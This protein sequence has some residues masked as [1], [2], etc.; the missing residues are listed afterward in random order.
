MSSRS[1]ISLIFAFFLLV[2]SAPRALAQTS[3]AITDACN[4]PNATADDKAQLNCDT[5]APAID[6]L[7]SIPCTGAPHCYG[8]YDKAHLQPLNPN[9]LT[10]AAKFAKAMN[11]QKPGSV[12]VC[13]AARTSQ[14]QRDSCNRPNQAVCGRKTNCQGSLNYCPHV[15]GIAIDFN[16]S[17]KNYPRLWAA[18]PSFGLNF[19]LKEGDPFH[20]E[21][22]GGADCLSTGERFSLGDPNTP[23]VGA[24]TPSQHLTDAIRQYL[25]GNKDSQN[26][27]GANGG[28]GA[29]P[30]SSQPSFGG[31][32]SSGGSSADGGSTGGGARPRGNTSPSL[33]SDQ[34]DTTVNS[35]S[36]SSPVN[37]LL[38][39][40]GSSTPR[41]SQAT[42][43]PIA[44]N[45]DLGTYTVGPITSS[46]TK[47]TTVSG[48]ISTTT[49]AL[50][51]TG[52]QTF[53]SNDLQHN[54]VSNYA[55]ASNST[56]VM[57]VLEKL[58][59]TLVQILARLQP[60]GGVPV[61]V[62]LSE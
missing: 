10:C 3:L 29:L 24:Q 27:G 8:R 52:G 36:G 47:P 20:A 18:A 32:G 26:Q 61:T 14:E 58:R 39:L 49:Y 4:N 62:P 23:D 45:N 38:N 48:V 22:G 41:G 25:G 46:S 34:I 40:I 55:P 60:F 33:V 42:G 54:G 50:A 59:I 44:L 56:F 43:T 16:E 13:Q 28:G 51:P 21:S 2:S 31:S 30:A 1:T 11:T 6:Y 5:R 19:R 15:K 7:A 53:T 57:S 17:S 37:D 9:F 12:C 35:S